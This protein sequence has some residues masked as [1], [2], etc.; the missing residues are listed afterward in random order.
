MASSSAPALPTFSWVSI[1]RAPARRAISTVASVDPSD[2]TWT[3]SRGTS[4][5]MDRRL[6]SITRA[7]LCA[8]MS[9]ATSEVVKE[10][11]AAGGVSSDEVSGSEVPGDETITDEAVGEGRGC[12]GSPRSPRAVTAITVPPFTVLARRVLARRVLATPGPASDRPRRRRA[13]TDSA[14]RT[15]PTDPH[16]AKLAPSTKTASTHQGIM[17]PPSRC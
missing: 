16:S 6:S 1:T 7:S 8:G 15:R 13:A 11:V 12:S 10:G 2:T 5:M 3:L 17:A 14:S 9:T 4:A